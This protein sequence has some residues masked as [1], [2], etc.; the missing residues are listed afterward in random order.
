MKGCLITVVI[1]SV[2]AAAGAVLVW[3][4]RDTIVSGFESAF[5]MPEYGEKE[6]IDN[7]YG[8]L[9]RSLDAAAREAFS[10]MTFGAAV[11]RMELAEPVLYVGVN[12]GEDKTDVIKRFEWSGKSTIISSGYGAGTL[13]NIDASKDIMIYKN[14]GPWGYMD[15]FVVYIEHAGNTEEPV[16]R[17]QQLAQ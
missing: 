7:E 14:D 6:Y 9:L 4:N 16:E 10:V 1:T 2:L 3:V 5:E 17:Q 8:V 15:N 12:Q 13:K 11:Q